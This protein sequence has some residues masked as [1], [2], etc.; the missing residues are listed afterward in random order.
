MKN[1]V[2]YKESIAAIQA[3]PYGLQLGL[4]QLTNNRI[5]F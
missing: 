5:R 2:D 1:F 4:K 3:V